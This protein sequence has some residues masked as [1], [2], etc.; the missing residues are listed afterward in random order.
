MSSM[1][2]V[3]FRSSDDYSWQKTVSSCS[4]ETVVMQTITSNVSILFISMPHCTVLLGVLCRRSNDYSKQA[5][6]GHAET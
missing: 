2:S 3:L 4:D 5:Q 1:P 6:N